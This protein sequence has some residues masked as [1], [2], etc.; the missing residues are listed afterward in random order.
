T[1]CRRSL[2]QSLDMPVADDSTLLIGMIARMV[3]Q[4]GL[5]LLMEAMPELMKL[6]VCFVLLGSGDPRYEQASLEWERQWPGR[7]RVRI[8]YDEILA[9]RILGGADVFLMPS[10]FEPCGLS[11]MYAMQYGVLPIVHATGGLK[12]TV[13]DL[14]DGNL[15]E[16]TGF[17]FETYQADDLLRTLHRALK[18]FQGNPRQWKTIQRRIMKQDRSWNVFAS[19]YIELYQKILS[20]PQRSLQGA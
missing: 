3:D 20:E 1:P 7:F 12:D 4:K 18:I 17:L 16:G 10:K 15:P 8:G 14:G 5:D 13:R 19:Q 2:L 9:H 6:P 11:Q